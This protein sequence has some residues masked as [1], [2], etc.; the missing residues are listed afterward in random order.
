VHQVGKRV[1]GFGEGKNT[2]CS[3]VGGWRGW[4]VLE[5]N[6]N[7]ESEEVQRWVSTFGWWERPTHE[8]VGT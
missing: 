8:T 6:M 5:W 2:E 4:W 3:L 7:I 1:C